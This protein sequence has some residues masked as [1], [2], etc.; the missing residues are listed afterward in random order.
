[1]RFVQGVKKRKQSR[2][3]GFI[4]PCAH[5]SHFSVRIFPQMSFFSAL[6]EIGAWGP[7]GR[8]DTALKRICIF[9]APYEALFPAIWLISEGKTTN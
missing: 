7:Q 4:G 8:S 3:L 2:V 6:T 1:M 5:C 9:L